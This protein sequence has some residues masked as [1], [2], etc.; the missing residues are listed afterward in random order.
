MKIITFTKDLIPLIQSGQKTQTR[1]IAR[2]RIATTNDNSWHRT[3]LKRY[4]KG[5]ICRILNSRYKPKEQ[6][7]FIEILDVELTRV[8]LTSFEDAI[9][10]GFVSQADFLSGWKKIHGKNSD[11][12]ELIWKITFKYLDKLPQGE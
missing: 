9:A 1:R 4:K 7:G 2:P 3:P 11:V 12:A 6:Y 8:M 10:E 5:D